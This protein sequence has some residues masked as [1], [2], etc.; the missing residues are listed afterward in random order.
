MNRIIFYLTGLDKY[1]INDSIN[2]YYTLEVLYLCIHIRVGYE[3]T[4][5]IHQKK[6]LIFPN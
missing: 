6:N 1:K 3:F 4:I 2:K 5:T